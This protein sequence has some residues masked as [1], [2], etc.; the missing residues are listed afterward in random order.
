MAF[1]YS[2]ILTILP[3]LETQE[4]IEQR[5]N[6]WKRKRGASRPRFYTLIPNAK[7]PVR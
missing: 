3:L 2:L 7:L 4:S 5:K 6:I 1:S